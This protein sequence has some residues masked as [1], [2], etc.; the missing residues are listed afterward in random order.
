M[1]RTQLASCCLL[2]SAF[3]LG[4]LLLARLDGGLAS[5]A[6]ADQVVTE[7]ALTFMTA[8]TKNDDE[9][10]FMIDNINARLLI[11][12]TDVNRKKMAV[13]ESI[14]LTE[15]FRSGAS[16]SRGKR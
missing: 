8:R 12:Q 7:D 15:Q 4:G 5:T 10:L 11:F 3:V 14:D 13:A 9:A 6:L 2:A 16:R 1:N